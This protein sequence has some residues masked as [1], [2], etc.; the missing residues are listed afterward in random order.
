M[1]TG[2]TFTN[3]STGSIEINRITQFEGI[4]VSQNASTNFSNAGSIKIGNMAAVNVGGILLID[5][6]FTNDASGI[7]EID[8]IT[9]GNTIS[10]TSGLSSLTNNG[11]MK[12]G[13]NSAV[14][15]GI[16]GGRP[17]NNNGSITFG[18]VTGTGI[19][20]G[21]P[22]ATIAVGESQ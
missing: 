11:M 13:L 19:N 3:Q 12:I 8:N 7:V 18:T 4:W 20:T 15:A 21:K 14:A 9:T 2:A 22:L 1:T 16:S 10:F 5:G 6:T 17:F